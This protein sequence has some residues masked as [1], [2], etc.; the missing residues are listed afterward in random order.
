MKRNKTISAML[1]ATTIIFGACSDSFETKNNGEDENLG[2]PKTITLTIGGNNTRLSHD[3]EDA[4]G[5]LK[6][7][8]EEDDVVRVFGG[9]SGYDDYKV[10]EGKGGSATAEF[11]RITNNYITGSSFNLFYPASRAAE[12]WDASLLNML[13]QIQT[14]AGETAHL[15]DYTY[16]TKEETTALNGVLLEHRTAVIRIDMTAASLATTGIRAITLSTQDAAEITTVQ[17]ADGTLDETSKQLTLAMNVTEGDNTIAYMAVLPGMFTEGN[18]VRLSIVSNTNPSNHLYY[19]VTIGEGKKYEAG[20]VYNTVLPSSLLF[21]KYYH[22]G[23]GTTELAKDGNGTFII[24]TPDKLKWLVTNVNSGAHDSEGQKYMLAIDIEVDP[25]AQWT[26]IGTT[27]NPFKGHFDGG[28]H[29]IAGTLKSQSNETQFDFGFFGY[30]GLS[31]GE[32]ASIRNLHVAA[33]ITPTGGSEVKR[34]YVGIVANVYNNGG[35]FNIENCTYTGAMDLT[36]T[37]TY[38]NCY[39]GGIAGYIAGPDGTLII[40][41]CQ[42]MGSIKANNTANSNFYAGGIAGVSN[43][44]MH[45]SFANVNLSGITEQT[46][47]GGLVGNNGGKVYKCCWTTNTTPFGSNTWATDPDTHHPAP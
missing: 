22:N 35:K 1:I 36:S 45:T 11:T 46:G 26:P 3:Y 42:A 5:I 27:D 25:D 32:E 31:T 17:R 12:T 21:F 13:G 38:D 41:R 33:D 23:T 19:E 20:H 2:L 30:V 9:T 40:E 4:T 18:G 28:G 6:V 47:L 43:A 24:D 14:N 29:T 16:L 34:Y 8:W 37:T 39:M 44:E 7:A 15:K 10:T